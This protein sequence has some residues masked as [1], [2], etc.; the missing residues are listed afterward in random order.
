MLKYHH[1]YGDG[2]CECAR[3]KQLKGFNRHWTSMCYEIEGLDGC[4][5][6]ECLAALLEEDEHGKEKT[7]IKK[8]VQ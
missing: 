4:Y 7:F 2:Q 8:S 5:C 3:C 1:L 6:W